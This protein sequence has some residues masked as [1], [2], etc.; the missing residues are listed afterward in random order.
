[1]KETLNSL[2]NFFVTLSDIEFSPE[3]IALLT[4]MLVVILVKVLKQP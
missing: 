2:A 3:V 1:M 4:L